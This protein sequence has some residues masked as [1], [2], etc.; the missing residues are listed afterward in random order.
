[1]TTENGND[2]SGISASGERTLR[3]HTPSL[4]STGHGVLISGSVAAAAAQAV[5]FKR[6]PKT[7]AEGGGEEHANEEAANTARKS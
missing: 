6:K 4:S 5:F 1:M 2:L 3:G 7:R